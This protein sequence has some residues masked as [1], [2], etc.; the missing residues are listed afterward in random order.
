MGLYQNRLHIYN[1]DSAEKKWN[2]APMK[3]IEN[4][5]TISAMAWK[6]DGSRLTIV[7]II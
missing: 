5:Y 4:I 7:S 2:E 1:Y 3:V 6:P